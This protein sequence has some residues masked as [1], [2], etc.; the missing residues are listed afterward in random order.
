M[1]DNNFCSAQKLYAWRYLHGVIQQRSTPLSGG[2]P[3]TVF[4][5]SSLVHCLIRVNGGVL[6]YCGYPARQ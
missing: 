6:Q 2:P 1:V 5:Y 4:T 3:T